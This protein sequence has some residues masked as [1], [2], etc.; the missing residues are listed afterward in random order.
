MSQQN[1][2]ITQPEDLGGVFSDF[3]AVWQ[4]TETFVLDF[5]AITAPPDAPSD[6]EQNISAQVVSRVRIPPGQVF[7]IMKAL[8]HQLTLWESRHGPSDAQN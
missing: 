2:N 4:T 3:V 7:E 1:Y 8:E 6:G 5:A